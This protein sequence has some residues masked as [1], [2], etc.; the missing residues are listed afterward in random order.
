MR[1]ASNSSGGMVTTG[2]AAVPAKRDVDLVTQ[3]LTL[4]QKHYEE[5]YGKPKQQAWGADRSGPGT[6]SLTWDFQAQQSDKIVIKRKPPVEAAGPY[7]RRR[8]LAR[9]R[10]PQ[11]LG[12]IWEQLRPNTR[13]NKGSGPTSQQ[14]ESAR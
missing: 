10:G 1:F 8:C 9:L 12:T 14:D 5:H 4:A 13:E 11:N 7:Q 6:L 3:R 2:E